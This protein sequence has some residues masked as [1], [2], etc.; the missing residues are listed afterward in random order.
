MVYLP[1][2]HVAFATLA[3]FSPVI[4]GYAIELLGKRQDGFH[5]I[6]TWT[7]MP[8]L[9]E[10]NNMPPSPFVRQLEILIMMSSLTQS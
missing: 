9:V 7:S 6:N 2:M 8:Q 3:I 1:K 5:W 10:S 4:Q